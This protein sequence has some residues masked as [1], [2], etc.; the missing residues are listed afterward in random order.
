MQLTI[1]LLYIKI[2]NKT[3]YSIFIPKMEVSEVQLRV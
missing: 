3:C 2:P 1:I